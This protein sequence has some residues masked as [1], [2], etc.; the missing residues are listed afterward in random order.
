MLRILTVLGTRPEGIKLAPVIKEL[1][2]SPGEIHSAVC[3]TGQHKDMLDQVLALFDIAPDY[4]LDLMEQDQSLPSLTARIMVAVSGV[5]QREKPDLVLV[6]GDTTSAMVAA[7]ASFYRKIRV[8]HVEA[9]L[10]TGDMYSPFPEEVNRRLIGVLATLHFAPTRAAFDALI[11][12]GV[13]RERV[14]LTGNPV[15]DALLTI[16]ND[17]RETGATVPSGGGRLLLVTAHR[18]ENFGKPLEDICYALREIVERNQDVEVVYPVHLNPNV[19]APVRA[20]LSGIDRIRLLPPLEYGQFAHLL[21]KAYLVLT[22]SGGIQEEAPVLGKPVLVMRKETERP[23]AVLAGTAKIVG[24]DRHAI[25]SNVELLLK[26]SAEYD[27]MA[28]AVSPF[29][30]GH[31]ARRIVEAILDYFEV[32]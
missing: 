26:D 11:A 15:V 28:N 4:A 7:L 9:G 12:E 21:A 17:C 19:Q 25:V 20:I 8:G 23:E 2:K 13:P 31:A 32:R 30:D 29:G 10:R 18:R 27:R 22:D 16:V 14:F 24:P 5:L 6:E 3:V 1:E